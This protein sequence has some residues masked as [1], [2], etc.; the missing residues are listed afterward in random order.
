[1]DILDHPDAQALLNDAELSAAAVRSCA[2][3]LTAFAQ[4]YLPRFH[5]E[6]HR[7][8]ALTVLRGKLSGLQRKTTEPIATL[9]GLKRRPLQL[10]VGGGGWDDQAVLGELRRHIAEELA[11]DDAVFVLDPSAFPKKGAASCGV[12]RQWCGRLGKIDNCQVGVFLAYVAPRGKALLDAQLY[13]DQDWA[14][15][16]RRRAATFV[17]AA[18]A[19]AEKWRV[20]LE[21]LDRAAPTCPGTG[22]LATTSSA[23][24]RNCGRPCGSGGSGTCWTC[25]ATPWCVT[26]PS[27]RRRRA[28]AA[29]RG[30]RRSSALIGGRRGSRRGGGA[31]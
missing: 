13:L 10:F 4:R 7:G 16:P 28:P 14:H 24:A 9:A 12:A 29:G 25:P 8:H 22:W 3:Q 20:G 1:M 31:R 11:D 26:W 6:E 18:V 15:D 5:R 23:A 19:F 17:P 30:C 2:D 21:L 27:G